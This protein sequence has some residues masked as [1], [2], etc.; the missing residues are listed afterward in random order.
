LNAKTAPQ[1]VNIASEFTTEA[2]PWNF[3]GLAGEKTAFVIGEKR[4]GKMGVL[5]SGLQR[6][7]S[8]SAA[9]LRRED[10]GCRHGLPGRRRA[11]HPRRDGWREKTILRE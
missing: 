3:E 2:F 10:G 7:P 8:R 9:E 6:K 5:D 1:G 11:G 4:A